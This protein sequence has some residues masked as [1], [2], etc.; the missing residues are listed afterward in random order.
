[1]NS[2]ELCNYLE[3]V[4]IGRKM[5][6]EA[7][8]H[9]IVSIRQYQRYRNGDGD[10]P[11]EKLELF[12]ERLGIP[13]KKILNEFE[14]EKNLQLKLV[15]EFYNAVV[16]ND[17]TNAKSIKEKITEDIIIEEEK[18][19][20]FNH[21]LILEDLKKRKVSVEDAFKE[22]AKLI[23]YPDILKHEYITDI[24]ALIL[25]ALLD[26]T[27]IEKSKLILDRLSQL[28]ESDSGI[29]VSSDSAIV[30]TLIVRRLIKSYGLQR[31][32]SQVINFSDIAIERGMKFKQYYLWDF[33]YYY[34][35]GAYFKLEYFNKFE[36]NL[37][38]CYSVLHM[39][40]NSKKIEKFTNWIQ[41]EFNVNFDMFIMK[42]LQKKV[43]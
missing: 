29:M 36:E 1:M 19:I 34:K 7:M 41:N 23:N 31:N 5:T 15:N 27:P 25:S 20:F 12:A 9:G 32:Y 43:K 24:E 4:R 38:K 8:L 16:N 3:K 26:L 40:G 42:Y 28:I 13:S 22:N 2:M 35:A 18:K 33:F 6:Q 39:E 30:F 14:Y 11:Y 21:A 37:F 10:L 17:F